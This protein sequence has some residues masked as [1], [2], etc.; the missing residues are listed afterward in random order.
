MFLSLVLRWGDLER[1]V[2]IEGRVVK[3]SAAESDAY[4]QSR[5]EGEGECECECE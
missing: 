4:F 1:S 3:V 2:R 5:C